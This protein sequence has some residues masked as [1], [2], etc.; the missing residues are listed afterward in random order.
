MQARHTFGAELAMLERY[1]F[2]TA[3][4]QVVIPTHANARPNAHIPPT[5]ATARPN[6]P[7]LRDHPL[8]RPW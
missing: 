8:P 3:P 4:L 6:A 1:V 2:G 5:R 7:T